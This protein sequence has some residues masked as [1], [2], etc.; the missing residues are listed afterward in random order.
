MRIARRAPLRSRS[1]RPLR[2][3]L[4]RWLE[5]PTKGIR[6]SICQLRRA[7]RFATTP[8]GRQHRTAPGCSTGTA[9]SEPITISSEK[10]DVYASAGGS[11]LTNSAVTL[12]TYAI[13]PFAGS[14]A[15]SPANSP[16]FSLAPGAYT[17]AQTVS[18][19][20]TTADAYVCY[21]VKPIG[22][23]PVHSIFLSPTTAQP[24]VWAIPLRDHATPEHSTRHQSPSRR[25]KLF[26][27]S[28]GTT[29]TA[30]PSSV[31]SATYTI[32]P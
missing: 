8:P 18:I 3:R 12:P 14:G 16:V 20:T 13:N 32:G 9:Y 26:M 29:F 1:G 2:S 4:S 23:D 11:G 19:S 27:Q 22:T 21:V 24:K 25:R 10:R 7:R 15:A 5:V 17:G 28:T 31:S 6:L 30:P